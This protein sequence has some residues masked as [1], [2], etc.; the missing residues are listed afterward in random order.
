MNTIEISKDMI[1]WAIVSKDEAA[2]SVVV[3]YW[4]DNFTVSAQQNITLPIDDDNKIPDGVE[5]ANLVMLHAPV[6][7]L[8]QELVRY[9][10]AT[11]VDWTHIDKLIAEA[12]G[13]IPSY[14]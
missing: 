14:D 6:E 2:H 5:L 11:M 3:H 13:T 12:K 10:K 1:K 7:L 8:N 9:K 4:A